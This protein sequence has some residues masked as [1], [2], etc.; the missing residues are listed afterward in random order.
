MLK[1]RALISLVIFF[2]LILFWSCASMPQPEEMRAQAAG[3]QLPKLPDEGKAMVYV[4]RPSTK[5]GFAILHVYIDNREPASEIGNTKGCRY[6]NFNITP[7]VHTIFSEGENWSEVQVSAKAGDIIFLMQEP[8]MPILHGARNKLVSLQ[9][10]EGKYYVKMMTQNP[11]AYSNLSYGLKGGDAGSETPAIPKGGT[12][13]A[14]ATVASSGT[15]NG[16]AATPAENQNILGITVGP[17]DGVRGVRVLT[18]SPQSPC[19]NVLKPGDKI[20][21]FDLMD[22]SGARVGGAKV[23]AGNFQTEAAK[24]KPGMTVQFLLDPRIF[25]TVNCAIPANATIPQTGTAASAK[26]DTFIGVVTG[27]NY[28]KG[29]GYSNIN[30]K[31][32]VT[33]DQGFQDIFY[34]RSDSKVFDAA[35][36]PMEYTKTHDIKDRKIAIE[37][38]TIMDG[39]GGDPSRSDFAYEIG[40][41]GARTVRLLQ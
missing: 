13:P 22:S 31:L 34:V 38:F 24:I 5:F 32:E 4:V 23:N 15:S 10:Y 20:F 29:V 1:N 27:G 41:K 21:V 37:Y 6:I 14:P 30:V 11:A 16:T 8:A 36:N 3:Y 25:Q 35:G 28:A 26:P 33:D 12:A 7:G 17:T 2:A 39:T 19:A 9:D 18:V 40:K